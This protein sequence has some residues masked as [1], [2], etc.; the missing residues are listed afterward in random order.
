MLEQYFDH[1]EHKRIVEIKLYLLD[2]AQNLLICNENEALKVLSYV[3][4]VPVHNKE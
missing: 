3:N 1:L 4:T 2:A